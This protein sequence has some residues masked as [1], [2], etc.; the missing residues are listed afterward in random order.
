[1]S[2][3]SDNG[4]YALR[5]IITPN[6]VAAIRSLCTAVGN[7]TAEEIDI[8]IEVADD[9]LNKGSLKSGYN[10]VFCDEKET[11]AVLGYAIWGPIPLTDKSHDLYWIVVDPTK[12]RRGIGSAIMRECERQVIAAGGAHLYLD[13]SAKESYDATRLFY[14]V[15]G[16]TVAAHLKDYYREHDDKVIYRKIIA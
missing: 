4:S 15:N 5:T 7:F 2:K 3:H 1:M 8:A 10:F 13:T 6:D 11:G 14:E 9:G 12:Q 16:F